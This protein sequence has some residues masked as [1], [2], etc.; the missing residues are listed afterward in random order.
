MTLITTLAA[1]PFLSAFLRIPGRGS[2][3]PVKDENSAQVSW[4]FKS[5]EIALLVAESLCRDLETEGFY[6]QLMD[7]DEGLSQARKDDIALSIIRSENTLTVEGSPADLPLVKTAVYEVIL[8]LNDS[9]KELKDSSDPQR[10]KREISGLEGRIQEDVLSLVQPDLVKLNLEGKNKEEI[11]AELVDL[12]ASGGKPLNREKALEAV[13]QREKTMSTGMEHGI[14][15]PHA[16]TEGIGEIQVAVGIKREGI[17]FGSLDGEKSRLFIMIISPKKTSG[18]H[19]QF[20]A[21]IGAVLKDDIIREAIIS[22]DT[23]EEAASLLRGTGS[24]P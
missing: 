13:F 18:P 11:L 15:L 19:V 20:L 5:G 21:A 16:K 14:A 8:A 7:I 9:F 2:R 17:D 12:I 3:K 10:M 23:P 4:D 1:P 22:A 24:A 6:V